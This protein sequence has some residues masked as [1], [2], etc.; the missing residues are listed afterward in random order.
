MGLISRVS[1]RTYREKIEMKGYKPVA[2]PTPKPRIGAPTKRDSSLKRLED[3]IAVRTYYEFLEDPHLVE[4]NSEVPSDRRVRASSQTRFS[5]AT[6][7]QVVPSSDTTRGRSQVKAPATPKA[8]IR[9]TS[10]GG[11]PAPVPY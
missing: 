5:S 4:K 10:K 7:S 9:S 6:S 1:S 11:P 8:Q 2:A 3:E